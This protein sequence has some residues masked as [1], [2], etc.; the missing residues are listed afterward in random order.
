MKALIFVRKSLKLNLLMNLITLN[1]K[2]SYLVETLKPI[3]FPALSSATLYTVEMLVLHAEAEGQKGTY[4]VLVGLRICMTLIIIT[5]NIMFRTELK[6]LMINESSRDLL[7][8]VRPAKYVT[9]ASLFLMM[10]LLLAGSCGTLV[11]QPFSILLT[12]QMLLCNFQI[13]NL[14]L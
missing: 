8:S 9:I 11:R 10:Q 12:P 2:A 6:K 14:F 3:L 4:S 13:F 5:P 7:L 1:L